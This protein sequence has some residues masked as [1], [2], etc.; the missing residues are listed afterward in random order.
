MVGVFMMRIVRECRS[1]EAV[2]LYVYVILVKIHREKEGI[3]SL[4]TG[5]LK[6]IDID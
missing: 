2:A 5:V 3:S 1:D 4:L 6:R